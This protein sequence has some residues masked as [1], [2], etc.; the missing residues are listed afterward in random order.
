MAEQI[1]W[2]SLLLPTIVSAGI[3]LLILGIGKWSKTSDKALESGV[4]L[5]N[6]RVSVDELRKFVEKEIERIQT[7]RDMNGTAV[8]KIDSEI[9][10]IDYKIQELQKNFMEI[11]AKID[12]MLSR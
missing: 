4:M 12:A 1:N 7:K 10:L 6:L 9:S 8:V 2:I 5:D 3:A 11:R